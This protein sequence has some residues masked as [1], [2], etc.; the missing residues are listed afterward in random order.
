MLTLATCSLS[1]LSPERPTVV[2]LQHKTPYRMSSCYRYLKAVVTCEFERA[3]IGRLY[4]E[5]VTKP[6]TITK[7]INHL[8]LYSA[9]AIYRLTSIS[10][11]IKYTER[12]R[13]TCKTRYALQGILGITLTNQRILRCR[14]A[15]NNVFLREK[16]F[17]KHFKL[18][19]KIN[20]PLFSMTF[21]IILHCILSR[22]FF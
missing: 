22:E 20:R 16:V 6:A 15:I 19:W 1:S 17:V 11:T 9:T 12:V 13:D 3:V 18:K 8:E 5:A 10:R 14:R 21:P 7:V 2:M 4:R